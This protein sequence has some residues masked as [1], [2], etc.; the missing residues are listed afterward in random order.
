MA[1][2]GDNPTSYE[3]IMAWATNPGQ[4]EGWLSR[5]KYAKKVMGFG[6]HDWDADAGR[7]SSTGRNLKKLRRSF[8][9]REAMGYGA[10]ALTPEQ[11]GAVADAI[12]TTLT[13]LYSSR[14]AEKKSEMLLGKIQAKSDMMEQ[15]IETRRAKREEEL[16]HTRGL[17]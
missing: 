6:A 5:N 1:S 16:A 14:D 12:E 9:Y 2:Y 7:F 15:L 17:Y 3:D 13:N 11:Q 10:G 4:V 8:G